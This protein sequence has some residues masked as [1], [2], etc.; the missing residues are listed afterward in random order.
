VKSCCPAISF[1]A[2][3]SFEAVGLNNKKSPYFHV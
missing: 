2:M 1:V 3:V